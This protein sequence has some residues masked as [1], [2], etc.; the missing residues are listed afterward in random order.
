MKTGQKLDTEKIR[1]DCVPMELIEQIAEVMTYGATKYNEDPR[2]PNWVKV[3]NGK[4]RYYAAMMR[5]LV[6]DMKGEKLDPDSGLPHLSHFLF[7]A[8]AFTHFRR[9]EHVD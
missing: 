5:H 9:E 1:W 3:E 6:A 2:D 7:N 8:M 4:H